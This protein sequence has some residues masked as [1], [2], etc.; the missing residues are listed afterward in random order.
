MKRLNKSKR[1]MDG[2][3]H[4]K[5]RKSHAS[6]DN[7]DRISMKTGNFLISF[8]F[9]VFLFSGCVKTGNNTVIHDYIVQDV[10]YAKDSKL[11][12][13]SLVESI[14]SKKGNIIT[15][16]EYDEQG[17]L[18]KVSQPMYENGTPMF[19]DGTVVG[20]YSYSDYVY[21]NEGL[22]EKIIY[23]HSNLYAGFMNLETYMYSYDK[24]GNK[25]KEVI[26]YPHAI[27]QRADSTLY[28]YDNNRL[29]RADIYNG[30]VYNIGLITYIEYEYDQQGN[31]VK[32]KN[33]S[34]T[35]NTMYSFSVHS[36]QNGVNVKTEVH[37]C[38]NGGTEQI[39]EIRRYY[40]KND[41]LIYLESIELSQYSSMMSGITKYDYY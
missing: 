30:G 21:N 38:Y 5:N 3:N 35:D 32:E 24:N 26:E 17:R 40:D 1:V 23:Y 19:E 4:S 20:L 41:N 8:I 9:Y 18:S 33:Y 28:F 34:G 27:P 22:L 14:N 25:L 36:Y 31:L 29:K 39:R 11:K 37:N 2:N 12:Q 13:I 16:Y 7:N 6:K 10:M 15:Q